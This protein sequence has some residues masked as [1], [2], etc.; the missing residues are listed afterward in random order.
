MLRLGKADNKSP[1]KTTP[2]W[3]EYAGYAGIVFALLGLIV[4]YAM[5][6]SH[7]SRMLH[8]GRL[9]LGSV[10]FA[11]ALGAFLGYRFRHRADDL[12]ERI[13]IYVFF[14][15]LSIFFIPLF[16]SL[17]NRLLAYRPVNVEEAELFR[18][19]AYISRTF[20]LLEGE[21]IEPTGHNVY[22]I[23]ENELYK[24]NV[25]DLWFE[26]AK[27]GDTIP[28]PLRRGFWGIRYVQPE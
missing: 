14:I 8:P 15:L 28:L 10:V 18:S 26:K 1:E 16:G 19:E 7:F 20:G 12:T 3:L 2:V 6:F 21:S 17:S 27:E 25:E 4:L 9:V 22:F 24:V 11:V 23:F 13:Q 5:E